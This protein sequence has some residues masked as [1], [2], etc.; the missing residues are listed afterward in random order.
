M[1]EGQYVLVID[2]DA[3]AR[4]LLSAVVSDRGIAVRAVASGS[5]ALTYI[6]AD[7]PAFVVL[8]LLMPEMDG[9][10]VLGRMKLDPDKRDIPILIVTGA[11]LD[12]DKEQEL[13]ALVL[14]IVYKDSMDT[15]AVGNMIEDALKG[16]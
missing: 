1:T 12:K 14:D 6:D 10:S 5:M 11:R 16:G 9:F 2:D 7:M 13:R 8:D 3:D 15:A 4:A